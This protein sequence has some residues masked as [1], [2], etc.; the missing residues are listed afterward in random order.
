LEIK[1]SNKRE[2]SKAV[3]LK[4]TS[5]FVLQRMINGM[6]WNVY[7]IPLGEGVLQLLAQTSVY[8]G[9]ST[10]LK[11]NRQSDWVD[12]WVNN[13]EI[14]PYGDQ[15]LWSKKT[16]NKSRLLSEEEYRILSELQSG[17]TGKR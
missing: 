10:G 17:R 6:Q 12:G 9:L 15:Q 8:E 7:G 16:E 14:L 1:Q 2:V 3:L 13:S 5:R 4:E 11:S